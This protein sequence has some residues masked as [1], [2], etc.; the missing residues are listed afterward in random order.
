MS[1]THCHSSSQINHCSL[2]LTHF[3]F[4][5]HLG[6]KLVEAKGLM[7][8]CCFWKESNKANASGLMNSAVVA[9]ALCHIM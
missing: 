1:R 2:M 7:E 4:G 9:K 6:C 5:T 8:K 3:L